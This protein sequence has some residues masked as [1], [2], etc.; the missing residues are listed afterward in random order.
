MNVEAETRKHIERVKQ[1]LGG[2]I[3]M[4]DYA[5]GRHDMSKLEEPEKST[6][7]VFTPKLKG[8][9]Y[10]SP[11]YNEFLAQMKPALDHHYA[12]N[13]HH[14]EHY[15]NGVNDMDLIDLIE[16]I[17]DWRAATERHADG[18]IMKSIEHNKGRFGI[19]DQLAQILANTVKR[20]ID[21]TE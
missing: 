1:F 17:C 2:M 20:R 10:G 16:M 13:A 5:R 19:S 7:E 18:D 6:F 9:T 12:E 11:Q 14:P 8:V 4:L 3:N 21:L 15:P